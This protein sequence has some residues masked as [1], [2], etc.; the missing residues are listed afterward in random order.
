MVA[1]TQEVRHAHEPSAVSI[2]TVDAGISVA[3]RNRKPV[4]DGTVGR[5]LAQGRR[6]PSLPRR[7]SLF[8]LAAKSL[9]VRRRADAPAI[10]A[11]PATKVQ[12]PLM[13]GGTLVLCLA[14]A[15]MTATAVD[16]QRHGDRRGR[17]MYAIQQTLPLRARVKEFYLRERRWPT[18]ADLGIEAQ[19]AY[20]AGG[21]YRLGPEGSIVISFSVLEEL[22]DRSLSFRPKPDASGAKLEWTC[23]ADPGLKPRYLPGD[24]RPPG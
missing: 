22:R 15:W 17:V 12:R 23:S 10:A 18:A 9:V 11:P 6:V 3:L 21:G 4:P 19:T 5:A 2:W 20:P 24:C 7:E 14:M 1:P 8:D 13:V 16:A